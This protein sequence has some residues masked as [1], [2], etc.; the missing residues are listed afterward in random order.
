[1]LVVDLI[2]SQVLDDLFHIEKLDNKHSVFSK[3]LTDAF[4]H[5][6]QLFEMKEHPGSVD[7]IE[8]AIKRASDI[9][10]EERLKRFNAAV[11][12]NAGCRSRRLH[13]ENGISEI[14]V[15]F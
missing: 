3:A 9:S 14:L 7:H 8:C 10:V 4:R 6:V 11:V 12:C 2:E 13:S 1:M 5:R 15:V